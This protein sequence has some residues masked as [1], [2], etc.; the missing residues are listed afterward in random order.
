MRVF[1]RLC[2]QALQDVTLNPWA[3]LLT[4]AAVTLMAF[5]V[6]IFLMAIITLDHQLGVIKGE[7]IFQVYWRPGVE[8]NL[9]AGQWRQ[10]RLLPGFAHIQ[11][12]TP[13]EALQELEGRIGRNSS[14]RNFPFLNENNPLPAT[15]LITFTPEAEDYERWLTET[16][17]YLAR[18]EGVERVSSTPLRDELGQAWRTVNSYVLRP[19]IL[20]LTLILG[21]VVG[22]TVRLAMLSKSQ[23]VEIL[24]LVGAF[25]WYIR[26]PMLV[27][28]GLQG[29]VGSALALFL[30]RFIH[31]QIEQI[32]NFPPILMEIQ[33]L[34]LQT[35]VLMLALPTLLG[36]V[37]GWVGI[38]R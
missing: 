22:N 9:I 11:T 33:F 4:L 28:G 17:S 18:L 21:L 38:K 25:D 32:L 31:L 16:T 29:L 27:I 15:A 8:Q 13:L 24:Q 36:I 5:L 3:Q 12:Y 23:E 19:I 1:F 37:G 7:T 34:N 30:L 10:L 6:G 14:S 26:I 35:I 2:K 20:F